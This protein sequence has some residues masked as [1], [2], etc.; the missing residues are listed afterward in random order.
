MI[1]SPTL[2][3]FV[4]LANQRRV[5]SV[6]AKL[7]ADDLT[8]VAVYQALCGTREG[9]FLFES[10]EAGVWSRYSFIGVRSAATLTEQGGQATWIGRE[11]V[12]IPADGD[13]LAVLRETLR[14]L[15][16]PATPASRRSTPAWWATSATTWC[17][18]SRSC[19]RPPST[20]SNSPSW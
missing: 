16:T 9:T 5:I 13:P 3:E 11:L 8:P 14:E 2:E 1:V 20:N 18:G 10:A 17:G 6:H 7:L 15:A 19:P 4:E 12:G